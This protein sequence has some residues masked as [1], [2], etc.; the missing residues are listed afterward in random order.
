M[1]GAAQTGREGLGK[2][3]PASSGCLAREGGGRDVRERGE[4]LLVHSRAAW[5]STSLA[6]GWV[7]FEGGLVG[8]QRLAEFEAG[9]VAS[10]HDQESLGFLSQV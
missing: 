7:F 5:H 6:V 10:A 8:P 9:A 3:A 1:R 2:D 4:G